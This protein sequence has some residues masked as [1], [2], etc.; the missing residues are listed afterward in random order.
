MRQAGTTS[1]DKITRSYVLARPAN[2]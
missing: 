2:N 1:V